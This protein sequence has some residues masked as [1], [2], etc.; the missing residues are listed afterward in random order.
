M[1]SELMLSIVLL[2][3]AA[4]AWT[5]PPGSDAGT[6][7]AI[8]MELTRT[9]HGDAVVSLAELATEASIPKEARRQYEKALKADRKGDPIRALEHAKAAAELAPSYFQAHAALAIAYLKAGDLDRADHEL[10][11][12][13]SLNP[14]YLPAQEIRGLVHYSR[15]DFREAALALQSLVQQAP[16]RDTG[17]LFLARALLKLGD[18]ERARYHVEMAKILGRNKNRWKLGIPELDAAWEGA[19]FQ[20]GNGNRKSL[21]RPAGGRGRIP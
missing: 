15:G 8:S 4:P 6:E 7:T 13:A 19:A 3:L 12:A 17:R 18:V 21:F 11:V 2:A 1:R 14:Q 16:C 9:Q 20:E 5:A 10:D